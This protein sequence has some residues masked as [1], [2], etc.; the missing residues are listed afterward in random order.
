MA[1][2]MKNIILCCD[3]TQSSKNLLMFHIS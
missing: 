3:A 1:K 2:T